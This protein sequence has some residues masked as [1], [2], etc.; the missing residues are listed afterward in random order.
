MKYAT[1]LTQ[2]LSVVDAGET[3]SV[4]YYKSPTVITGIVDEAYPNYLASTIFNV[5]D[6]T[7]IPELKRIYRC[8]AAATSGIFPLSAAG[9]IA[10]VDYGPVNSYRMFSIDDGIGAATTGTNL[11]MEIPFNQVDTIGMIDTVFISLHVEQIDNGTLAVLSDIVINGKDIGCLSFAEYFYAESADVTRIIIDNLVWHPNST[12]KLTFTGAIGI[13]SFVVGNVRELGLTLYGTNLAL[14][15][16]S[17]I[18]DNVATD[19]RTVIRYGHVRVLSAKVL[20]NLDEFNLT[21]QKIT[22][23]IGKNILFIP[24][25]NDSFNEMSHIAY[26]EKLNL[27]VDNPK[28]IDTEITLVGV[29][30]K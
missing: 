19:T 1:P 30:K 24:T 4:T 8:A 10:W 23:I 13:S 12:L 21:A 28:V 29:V 11:Y 18:A 5:G 20:F 25:K 9:K 17:K 2:T 6:Y 26:I 22:R 27:P 16:R 3:Y 7:I 15:D 14:E